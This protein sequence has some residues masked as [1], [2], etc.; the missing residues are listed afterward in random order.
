MVK[1]FEVEMEGKPVKLEFMRPSNF[2]KRRWT[3]FQADLVVEAKGFETEEDIKKDPH[4][5][6]E[7]MLSVEDKKNE[8]LAELS[9]NELIKKKEDCYKIA[10]E[11]LQEI[12]GWL[13]KS[14]GLG[15]KNKD[16]TKA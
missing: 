5:G 13:N 4:K 12:Y 3:Q 7:L 8:F 15:D 10:N 6:T 9:Q 2:Y 14:L 11:D 1:V 16:F